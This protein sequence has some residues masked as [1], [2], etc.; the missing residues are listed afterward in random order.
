VRASRYLKIAANR[1]VPVR[2]PLVAV[3]AAPIRRD[4]AARYEEARAR[5]A[6]AQRQLARFHDTDKPDFERWL[7]STFGRLVGQ[8]RGA[9]G[10]LNRLRE[11]IFEVETR[12]WFN[13]QSC[14]AA[15]R[16]VLER[17]ARRRD[18]TGGPDPDDF[19]EKMRARMEAEAKENEAE[20]DPEEE[21]PERESPPAR[22]HRLGAE[23]EHRLKAAYRSMARRLHPDRHAHVTAQMRERWH[24]AQQA[25]LAGD[26]D[27]LESLE[28]LCLD[29]EE[30]FSAHSA[31]SHIL[32]RAKRLLA[33]VTQLGTK[34][35]HGK[36][37]PAW[38][39]SELG[40]RGAVERRM[41]QS[42]PEQT[43]MVRSEVETLE[44]K[45]AQWH[46]DATRFFPGFAEAHPLKRKSRSKSPAPAPA[47][48]AKP[49]AKAKPAAKPKAAQE[50]PKPKAQAPKSQPKKK[51]PQARPAPVAV[52]KAKQASKSAK[53]AKPVKAAKPIPKGKT[54]H[55]A[56]R[57]AAKKPATAGARR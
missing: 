40:D 14:A 52:K 37:D 47:A 2:G 19:E 3:D 11:L 45:V 38:G 7:Q 48:K 35:A 55:K 39:F 6:D 21:S 41:A 36:K 15:Y 30:G 10:E 54:P 26:V 23:K 27:L 8:L 53:P 49:K 43:E 31:V 1:P 22:A 51:A 17:Q 32:D 25:Y 20:P 33:S 28:S 13:S 18:G 24:A 4:A 42:L 9:Q 57:A 34:I 44:E 56:P 46:A 5:F 29:E 50:K 12:T 16:D